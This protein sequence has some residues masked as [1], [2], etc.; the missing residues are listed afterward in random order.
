[1]A[2]HVLPPVAIGMALLVAA[3]AL[4]RLVGMLRS[5]SAPGIAGPYS[6]QAKPVNY[7]LA[8]FKVAAIVV[9][10]ALILIRLSL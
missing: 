9:L 5:G 10:C 8:V 1:M 7:W 2:D 6:R 3:Y 4:V